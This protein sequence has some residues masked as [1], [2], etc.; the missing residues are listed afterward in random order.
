MD[1]P[2][3]AFFLLTRGRS[4]GNRVGRGGFKERASL[5]KLTNLWQVYE[6]GLRRVL[7]QDVQYSSVPCILYT[8]KAGLGWAL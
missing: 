5:S 8:Q 4:L 7:E 6:S 3:V 2:D 1:A